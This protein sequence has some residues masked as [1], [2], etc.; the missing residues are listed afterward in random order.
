MLDGLPSIDGFPPVTVEVWGP[1]ALFTR[2]EAKVERLT[3]PVMTPSA[4][5]GVLEAIFWKPEFSWQIQAIEVLNP[6]KEATVLRNETEQ[7]VTWNAAL[8][9]QRADTSASRT[10]RSATY[11]KDV[12]YRVHAHVVL[13]P[14]AN[15]PVAKYR[16]QFRRR[17]T[18][19]ACFSQL[20]HG[21]AR[22]DRH[23]LRAPL[24]ELFGVE[25]RA[26]TGVEHTLAADVT[27]QLQERRPVVV[28]VVRPI[29]RVPLEH[30]GHRVVH[31]SQMIV[32]PRDSMNPLPA[33][34][35]S[36]NAVT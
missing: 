11:L 34:F 21:F 25:A 18:R 5:I 1:A 12:R 16:D 13:R 33:R 35:A 32:H 17:V 28:R 29:G 19:G 15:E 22:V 10:Q 14:R 31:A 20:D 4:A 3:Y 9:G 23:D 30:R 24:D 2:P 27:E 8:Q 36:Q 6:F 7:V 26:T